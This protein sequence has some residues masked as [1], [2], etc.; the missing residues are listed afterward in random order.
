M[1]TERSLKVSS[2]SVNFV[3]I[4]DAANIEHISLGLEGGALEPRKPRPDF[5]LNVCFAHLI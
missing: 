2:R 5:Y 4:G 3:C 1:R